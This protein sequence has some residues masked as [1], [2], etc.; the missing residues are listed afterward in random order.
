MF[1]DVE[2][3]RTGEFWLEIEKQIINR[4]TFLVFLTEDALESEAVRREIKLALRRKSEKQIIPIYEA[5][6]DFYNDLHDEV[7]ELAEHNGIE[8][9]F[10]HP[11]ICFGKLRDVLGI[12]Q[13]LPIIPIA[14]VIVVLIAI[15]GIALMLNAQSNS[16][17]TEPLAINTQAPS[18][19]N[20]VEQTEGACRGIAIDPNP[21]VNVV[22]LRTSPNSATYSQIRLD[23]GQNV[24]I[25]LKDDNTGWYAIVDDNNGLMGWLP[26]E[27]IQL[28]EQCSF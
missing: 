17:E 21:M 27:N 12:R 20:T 25:S 10:R 11:E 24:N 5:G 18:V 22:S 19:T 14:F 3:L 13:T 6:F 2:S 7:K 26:P 23:V 4:D 15:I 1:F 16:P 28:Q 8:Y 9:D